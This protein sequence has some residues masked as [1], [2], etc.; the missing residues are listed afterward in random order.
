MFKEYA[1]C[2]SRYNKKKLK[3]LN[4]KAKKILKSEKLKLSKN[5]SPPCTTT[6]SDDE[7]MEEPIVEETENVEE[8]GKVEKVE[9]VKN[10]KCEMPKYKVSS[11]GKVAKRS[12]QKQQRKLKKLSRDIHV[13]D[14]KETFL[15]KMAIEE[16]PISF[17]LKSKKSKKSDDELSLHSYRDKNE[18]QSQSDNDNEIQQNI[19]SQLTEKLKSVK[20]KKQK[21]IVE[22]LTEFQMEHLRNANVPFVEIKQSS[23]KKS[24]KSDAKIKRL[25]S[26][27]VDQ[28]SIL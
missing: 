3:R 17:H 6:C 8:L 14:S 19:L 4:K 20:K 9:R 13:S 1:D 15:K 26:N 27:L 12:K 21:V 7:K 23:R 16:V 10:V 28:M 5:S 22:N 2:K 25:A 24:K 18:E 11:S